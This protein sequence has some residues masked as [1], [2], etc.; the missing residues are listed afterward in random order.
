M[1][2]RYPECVANRWLLNLKCLEPPGIHSDTHRRKK[3]G[4]QH[5]RWK[6]PGYMTAVNCITDMIDARN[7]TMPFPKNLLLVATLFS[8]LLG[9]GGLLA[10]Q[11]TPAP[12]ALEML[13][14]G[15]GGPGAN[16]RA[17]AGYA[18]LLDGTP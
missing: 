13:V 2:G 9:S 8:L 6:Y 11:E 12:A 17:G 3:Y 10:A 1:P 4:E 18:L 14:L 5:A 7:Q 15:S 16:G